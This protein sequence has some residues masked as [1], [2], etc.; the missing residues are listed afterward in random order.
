MRLKKKQ[1][2]GKYEIL[3]FPKERKMVIDIMEQGMNKHYIKALIELD[4]TL[5]RQK[6]SDYKKQYGKPLSFTGWIMKCIGKAA[7]EHKDVHA[8]K[9]SKKKIY[10]FE[11]VDISISVER[12]INEQNSP[13]PLIIRKTNAK[14][15]QE[16]T[17]EIL[18]AKTESVSNE[19]LLGTQ[20]EEKLKRLFTSLPKFIRKIIYW[21]FDRD[22]L[23]LKDFAGTISLTSFGRSSSQFK[24]SEP[25][26]HG[27]S[28]RIPW[29]YPL[30]VSSLERGTEYF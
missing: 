26:P 18:N 19:T 4:V 30:N 29:L 23:F 25:Y 2:I 12:I 15:V 13:L 1:S 10:R 28:K 17:N 6:I 22:P 7:N 3:K 9:K 20:K 21:K 14:T 16:I 5:G 24:I 11:D 8:L 27:S